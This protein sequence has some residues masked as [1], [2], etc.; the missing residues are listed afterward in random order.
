MVK[1]P[2]LKPCPF[3]PDGGKPGLF[4]N[5]LDAVVKC[6]ACGAAS[7][8]AMHPGTCGQDNPYEMFAAT[9]EK[10]VASW[11]RRASDENGR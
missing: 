10:A 5:R 9:I 3:C 2:D 8:R 11:N 4:V 6:S 1:T 7:A